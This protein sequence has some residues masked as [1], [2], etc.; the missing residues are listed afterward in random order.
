MTKKF[1]D[2]IFLETIVLKVTKILDLKHHTPINLQN[3]QE[4]QISVKHAFQ[5]AVTM[6]TSDPI[7]A[8]FYYITKLQDKYEETS[9]DMEAL[10]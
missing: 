5:N 2:I 7:Q 3:K 4:I 10:S 8:K 9:Y 6:A 1:L